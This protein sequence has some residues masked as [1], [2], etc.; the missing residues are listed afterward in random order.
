MASCMAQNLPCL[1]AAK[2]GYANYFLE[3]SGAID[4]DHKPFADAGVVVGDVV[5]EL[6]RGLDENSPIQR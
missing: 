3:G 5:F 4:D 2:L 6:V 1:W